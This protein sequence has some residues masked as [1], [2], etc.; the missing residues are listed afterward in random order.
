V[1]H[2]PAGLSTPGELAS[3]FSNN[4]QPISSDCR[5]YKLSGA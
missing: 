1:Y 3:G 5:L 4:R 2:S